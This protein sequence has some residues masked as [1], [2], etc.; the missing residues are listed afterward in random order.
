MATV[1]VTA[2]APVVADAA[3]GARATVAPAGAKLVDVH[4]AGDGALLDALEGVLRER[5]ADV[6]VP[7]QGRFDRIP[8]VDPAAVV[9]P[10]ETTQDELARIWVDLRGDRRYT[11]YIVDGAWERVLVRHL[12]RRANPEVAF[13]EI[14]H[15]VELAVSALAAGERIGVVRD[16]ARAD[17]AI[18]EPR[19]G[20]FAI[21]APAP[22]EN[23][24]RPLEEPRAVAEEPVARAQVGAF[25]GATAYSGAL[26]LASGPGLVLD[27]HHAIGRFSL[28]G[29][30][31]GQVL[32]PSHADGRNAT[33]RLTGGNAFLLADGK[34]A[35]SPRD[36]LALALGLGV[37]LERASAEGTPGAG[38]RFIDD[39][40]AVSPT[41]R[42]LV[43]Y[44][45]AW[46]LLGTFV[47]AGLDVPLRNTRYVLSRE[48]APLVLF[49]PW[50]ARPFAL[51]GITFP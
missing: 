13:E 28:G 48:T 42:A 37:Q 50:V 11:V 32:L 51:A 26:E 38:V 21:A 5:L 40:E 10:G 47:G 33:V 15:I 27:V 23:L 19:E 1:V 39:V 31:M 9:T 24:D 22:R 16:V 20:P 45:H 7:I 49:E 44:R 6:P 34:L 30:A 18:T 29:D 12:A 36:T 8:I 17:L 25:W 3:E 2:F 14:G 41:L 46:P 43:R 35:L 4:L